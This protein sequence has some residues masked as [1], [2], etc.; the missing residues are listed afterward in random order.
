MRLD[1]RFAFGVERHGADGRPVAGAARPASRV[2]LTSADVQLV[3]GSQDGVVAAGMTL[4]WADVANAAVAMVMVVPTHEAGCRG[5][6]VL[7]ISEALGGEFRSVLGRSEQR[8]GVG[9]VITH[10]GPRV[11][12][13]HT[14]PVEHREHGGG[15]ER[16]AVV[17]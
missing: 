1:D 2:D 17:A 6:C 7:K 12:W 3:A 14:Q 15:L 5:A 16:G 13:L 4:G 8:L 10:A 11:R 9:V